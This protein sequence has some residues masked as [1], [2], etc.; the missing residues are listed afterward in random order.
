MRGRALAWSTWLLAPAAWYLAQQMLDSLS[1]VNCARAD[2]QV[3]AAI[4]VAALLAVV[5]LGA[6][7]AY[8]AMRGARSE[9]D[10][11]AGLGAGLIAALFAMALLL[12]MLAGAILPACGR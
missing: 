3:Q 8:W 9:L 12:Q 2:G 1:R 10:R 4:D 5:A 11:F 6:G 7:S